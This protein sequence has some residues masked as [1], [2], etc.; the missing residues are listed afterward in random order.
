[1]Y[2]QTNGNLLDFTAPKAM[3]WVRLICVCRVSLTSKNILDRKIA[4]R[5]PEVTDFKRVCRI[6]RQQVKRN[7]DSSSGAGGLLDLDLDV[8]D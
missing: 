5:N 2:S 3:P 8:G 4:Y 6:K 1:M 7:L